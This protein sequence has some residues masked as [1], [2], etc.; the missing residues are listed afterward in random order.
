MGRSYAARRESGW[1]LLMS[2]AFVAVLLW[3]PEWIFSAVIACARWLD[4]VVIP[5]IV[6]IIAGG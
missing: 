6:H 2:A 4:T 3:K 5:P 1:S